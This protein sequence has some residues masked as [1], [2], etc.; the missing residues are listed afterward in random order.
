MY[1]NNSKSYQ[2]VQIT[3]VDIVFVV[4]AEK[5]Y[6]VIAGVVGHNEVVGTTN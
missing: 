6:T 5:G 4:P 1:E 3:C 2:N